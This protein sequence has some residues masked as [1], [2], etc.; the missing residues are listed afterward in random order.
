MTVS[1]PNTPIANTFSSPSPPPPPVPAVPASYAR[2]PS[3]SRPSVSPQSNRTIEAPPR[4][5]SVDITIDS[6][7][8]SPSAVAMGRERSSHS[9]SPKENRRRSLSMNSAS[10][11]VKLGLGVAGSDRLGAPPAP[12]RV[13]SRSEEERLKKELQRWKLDL[14]GVLGSIG[15]GVGGI[16]PDLSARS[17]SPSGDT[18]PAPVVLTPRVDLPTFAPLESAFMGRSISTPPRRP[19]WNEEWTQGEEPV[20]T[21]RSASLPT[22]S[23]SPLPPLPSEIDAEESPELPSI[24]PVPEQPESSP[25]ELLASPAM[26]SAQQSPATTLD[27]SS[28]SSKT[29]SALPATLP[30]GPES[31]SRRHSLNQEGLGLG[32]GLATITESSHSRDS[33]FANADTTPRRPHTADASVPPFVVTKSPSPSTNGGPASPSSTTP[34]LSNTR[35]KAA[36]QSVVTYPTFV[37][38]ASLPGSRTGSTASLGSDPSL[39]RGGHKSTEQALGAGDDLPSEALEEKARI[40]AQRCWDED[41]SFLEPKKIAEWLGSS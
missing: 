4:K 18:P 11:A 23:L 22:S 31:A 14:D 25:V 33:S 24:S 13:P 17:T 5:S 29:P 1:T 6:P 36:R 35:N 20:V 41:T 26:E 7:K 16:S 19:T 28:P 3:A 32:L 2:R 27:E 39:R 37:R 9:L 12:M 15:D 21:Q 34:K 10:A 30:D 38:T 8:L 40:A